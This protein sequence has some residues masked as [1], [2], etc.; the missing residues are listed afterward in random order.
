MTRRILIE[1]KPRQTLKRRLVLAIGVATLSLQGTATLPGVALAAT[2]P[3]VQELRAHSDVELVCTLLHDCPAITGVTPAFGPSGSVTITGENLSGVTQV[4]FGAAPALSFR[5]VPPLHPREQGTLVATTPEPAYGETVP[6][7]ALEGTSTVPSR[8]TYSFALGELDV[9]GPAPEC[10]EGSQLPTWFNPPDYD[11]D[12]NLSHVPTTLAFASANPVLHITTSFENDSGDYPFQYTPVFDRSKCPEGYTTIGDGATYSATLE[13]CAVSQSVPSATTVTT[14]PP[15]SPPV[16]PCTN[17]DGTQGQWVPGPTVQDQLTDGQQ[18]ATD[19]D[20][21]TTGDLALQLLPGQSLGLNN[22]TETLRVVVEVQATDS[23]IGQGTFYKIPS[24][25]V[26]S[27]SNPFNVILAP[28]AAVQASAVPYTIIYAPPGD[29]STATFGSTIGFGTDYTVANSSTQSNSEKTEQSIEEKTS[30]SLG[31][32]I[33][34][35]MSVF[36]IDFDQ[37]TKWDSSTKTSFGTTDDLS[38]E[39]SDTAAFGLSRTVSPDYNDWPGDGVT[40]PLLATPAPDGSLYD[41]SSTGLQHAS[42]ATLY[43]HEAFWNDVFQIVLHPQYAVYSL[44]SGQTQYVMLAADPSMGERTVLELYDC[45]LGVSLD[46]VSQ[47]EVPYTSTGLTYASGGAVTYTSSAQ[48]ALISP[49]EAKDLLA[50]DPFFADGTQDANIPANRGERLAP[51][52]YGAYASG[53]VAGRTGGSESANI[54]NPSYTNTQAQKQTS[55]STMTANVDVSDTIASDYGGGI[56]IAGSS[57]ALTYGNTQESDSSVTLTFK[58]STAV[59]TSQVTSSTALLSDVDSTTPGAKCPTPTPSGPICHGALLDESRVNI[60]L[61]RLFGSLMYVDPAAPRKPS[62]LTVAKEASLLPGLTF[63]TFEGQAEES[64]GFTDVS[65]RS[66]SGLAI[67]TL[68]RIGVMTGFGRQFR[69][70]APFTGAELATSLGHSVRLSTSSALK[71]LTG[72]TQGAD[73]ALTEKGLAHAISVAL[74]VAPSRA[75]SYVD[76]AFAHD[77]FS[78]SQI[79]SRADAAIALFPALTARCLRGCHVGS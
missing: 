20:R 54:A 24:R 4:M 30:L 58:D 25:D 18:L 49:T 21:T 45:E 66:A 43:N 22:I 47:C 62:G 2:A 63:A 31:K 48:Y 72:S 42:A 44:G 52:A 16:G 33:I 57:G 10:P 61:D 41:C 59:S 11:H 3:H 56:K 60:F 27:E 9:T 23:Y 13:M 5:Y 51:W 79:V 8:A 68:T 75:D 15:G 12:L 6:V 55:N 77:R 37:S 1:N 74:G 36:G 29:L 69:P 65:P 46:G 64:S 53:A 26:R 39:T 78:G 67:G 32:D 40:C 71:T 17:W 76:H 19:L 35:A 50:L 38:Q 14:L 73:Q 28:V 7:Y 70:D 34:P